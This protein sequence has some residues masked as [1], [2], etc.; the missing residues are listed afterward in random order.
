LSAGGLV[1]Q[2]YE[3]NFNAT[4]SFTKEKNASKNSEDQTS[5]DSDDAD[6]ESERQREEDDDEE[7]W[8][9]RKPA[10]NTNKAD[11]QMRPAEPVD[12]YRESLQ[13]LKHRKRLERQKRRNEE[14]DFS[15]QDEIDRDVTTVLDIEK[16]KRL[17]KLL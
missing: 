3:T 9:F 10:G 16:L 12:A 13:K 8:V 17:P 2:S 11:Q 15:D 6:S 1:G 14:K 4:G 5:E 7:I